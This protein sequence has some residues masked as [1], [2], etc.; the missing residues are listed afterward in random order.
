MISGL[1]GAADNQSDGAI[2]LPLFLI[3]LKVERQIR[4]YGETDG[5]TDDG[6]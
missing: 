1:S 3:V 4:K 6:P 5:V 2:F